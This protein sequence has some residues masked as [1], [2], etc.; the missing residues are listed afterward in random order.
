MLELE[1]DRMPE[2]SS[3][4]RMCDRKHNPELQDVGLPAEKKRDRYCS[5]QELE[6]DQ[7]AQQHS[8]LGEYGTRRTLRLGAEEPAC[9]CYDTRY[10]FAALDYD[11]MQ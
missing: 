8:N 9:H 1:H 11:R 7:M 6:C 2:H 5:L 10:K 4:L 3:K